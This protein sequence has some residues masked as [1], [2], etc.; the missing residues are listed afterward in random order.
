M[1]DE[2][3][4]VFHDEGQSA[5]A[6]LS[7]F[8]PLFTDTSDFEVVTE[9]LQ[10]LVMDSI[11]EALMIIPH[12]QEI[13]EVVF[14]IYPDKAPRSDAFS[15]RFFQARWDIFKEAVTKEIHLFVANDLYQRQN[16]SYVQLIPKIVTHKQ[17][18]DYRPIA[19]CNI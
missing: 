16:K 17:I 15:A 18:S 10:P 7:Y 3:G 19:L 4:S 14:D 5:S 8:Q 11:N 12:D 1:E 6:I 13:K 9:A 2:N